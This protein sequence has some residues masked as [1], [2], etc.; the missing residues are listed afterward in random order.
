MALTDQVQKLVVVAGGKAKQAR[1]NLSDPAKR[2]A[3]VEAGRTAAVQGVDLLTD[4]AATARA[5]I[6]RTVENAMTPPPVWDNDSKKAKLYAAAASTREQARAAKDKG[7]ELI[8]EHGPKVVKP[9][10]RISRKAAKVSQDKT[11]ALKGFALRNR[12]E[13][14]VI[15]AVANVIIGVRRVIAKR[16]GTKK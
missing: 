7:V 1:E 3:Y 11:P 6:T 2:A 13:I 15:L 8:Q 4:T 12:D 10:R 5:K 16:R 14:L 9:A